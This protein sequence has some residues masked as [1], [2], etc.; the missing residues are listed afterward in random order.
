M[1]VLL[2]ERL[3]ALSA[4]TDSQLGCRGV[5]LSPASEDASFRRYFRARDRDKTFIVMDAPP[6]REDSRPYIHAAKQLLALGLNVPEILAQDLDQGFL[7]LTD[8]GDQTYLSQLD[9][10]SVERLYADALAALVVLQTGTFRQPDGFPPYDRK[11]LRGEM[12]LF[13]QWYIPY[14]LNIELTDRQHTV[15]TDAFTVLENAALSQPQVWVHRDY[16]SRNLMVTARNNPGILDFQD[17]VRGPVTYDLVSL[18]RD[19]YIA[20]PPAQVTDWVLGY[21]RLALQSGIPVTD[22]EQQFLDWFDLTGIQR[23]IK[24]L[25][26]FTRLYHRDGKAGFLGDIPRVLTYLTAATERHPALGAFRDLLHDLHPEG[27]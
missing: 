21:H 2:D 14:R 8:L 9:A 20:W 17:A 22:D 12:E 25:G 19:C 16:H 6:E 27:A 4:W 15:I 3:T 1:S 18:L 11:L 7:L 26:I 23:H 13:Q 10:G 24:V 5:E